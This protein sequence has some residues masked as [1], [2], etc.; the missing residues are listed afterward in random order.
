M[1]NLEQSLLEKG[2]QR[3]QVGKYDVHT[4]PEHLDFFRGMIERENWK[5]E[6]QNT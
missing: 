1:M 4:R 6:T 5:D 3:Y 2:Y